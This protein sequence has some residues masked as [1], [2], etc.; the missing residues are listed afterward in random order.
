M[1][2]ANLQHGNKITVEAVV[3]FGLIGFPLS[4]S[5]SKGFFESKFNSLG[6]K[7]FSYSNFSIE[8]IED[9]QELLRSDL[10]GLNVTIPYKSGIINYVNEIDPTALQIGAVNTLVRTGEY[11]WKGFNTD[12]IGFKLSL[13]A[14]MKGSSFPERALILGTGGVAKAIK[15]ALLELG[16]QPS[17]VSRGSNG[18]YNY[19]NINREVINRHRLI[20]NATP[21][22]MEPDKERYPMIP[23]EYLCADHWLFD[24]VYNPSNTLFLTRGQQM[25]AHLMNGLEMLHLQAEHAW[26]IW[27]SYGRF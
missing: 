17:L 6:L 25:G 22:G 14:W 1:L 3:K 21:V 7:D 4:H 24:V 23:Y 12:V 2:L 9:V 10:F 20:I 13:E 27:K 15:Y 18:D 11:S 8:K 16:I 19:D 26:F 5:F